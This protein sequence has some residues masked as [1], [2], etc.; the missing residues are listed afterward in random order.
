M[1]DWESQ[2]WEL[3]NEVSTSIYDEYRSGQWSEFKSKQL[4]RCAKDLDIEEDISNSI[5]YVFRSK[6]IFFLSIVQSSFFQRLSEVFKQPYAQG[7]R[8]VGHYAR[9]KKKSAEPKA[10]FDRSSR[11]IYADFSKI[12]PNE[13]LLIFIHELAHNLDKTLV[14]SAEL[15][16]DQT[17]PR[18]LNRLSAMGLKYSE[19]STLTQASIQSYLFAGLNCGFLAE[20][21][22]WVFTIQYYRE[23]LKLG[24]WQKIEWMENIIEQKPPGLS[25]EMFMLHYLNKSFTDPSEEIFRLPL[26]QEALRQ[27]RKNIIDGKIKV[28]LGSLS[29]YLVP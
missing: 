16:K 19:V 1:S 23:G 2:R 7:F 9:E 29:S 25:D 24:V 15:Y 4:F 27:L 17:V 6:T 12:P 10:A 13:W 18:E 8:M 21:R 20:W 26:T 3:L 11:S 22:A 28:E 14:Q 5:S